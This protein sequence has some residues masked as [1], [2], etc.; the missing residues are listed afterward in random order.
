MAA[1]GVVPATVLVADDDPLIRNVLRAALAGM[2]HDIVEARSAT[3]VVEFDRVQALDLVILDVHMP[4]PDAA[5]CL[6]ALRAREPAPRVLLL[7]G[8][9]APL[10]RESADGFARKPVDLDELTALVD[11]MLAAS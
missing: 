10:L 6:S 7:S 4:G 5:E 1:S 2:G 11:R 3:E 8:Q 9:D